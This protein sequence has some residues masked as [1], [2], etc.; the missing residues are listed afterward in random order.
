MDTT[1]QPTVSSLTLGDI[2]EVFRL[3][4]ELADFEE[5]PDEVTM[6]LEELQ[7]DFS[8]GA[9]YGFGIKQGKQLLGMAICFTAY[10]SWKGRTLFLEDFIISEE[11]RRQ[12]LGKQLFE[13]VVR[14]AGRQDV[15]RMAWQ[16]LRS[17]E[18]AIR[19]YENYGA[20][21]DPEWTNGKL[22]R[23]QIQK[24]VAEMEGQEANAS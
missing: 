14:E 2:P 21:M 1:D 5:A 20:E 17:N 10:S 12:G 8:N 9:F 24:L 18:G 3:I 16:V 11:A 4:N 7:A 6:S 15:R 19:F 22:R 23:P 13:E